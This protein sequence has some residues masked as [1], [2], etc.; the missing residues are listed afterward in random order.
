M[1]KDLKNIFEYAKNTR[2]SFCPVRDVITRISDKWSML[3]IYALG[4]YGTLRF[5]ELK[6]KIGDVSQRMLTVT[7]R[8]LEEDGMIKRKVYP[9]IPPR[10]EYALTPLGEGL[11]KQVS[12]LGDWAQEHGA[13]IIKNRTKFAKKR[14][15]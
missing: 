8:N 2:Y 3:T 14:K 10:V 12:L 7:L 9:E 11:L 6:V 5:N 13:S 1:E 15:C 4:A